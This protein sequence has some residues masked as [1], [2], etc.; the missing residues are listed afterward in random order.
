MDYATI[1][2]RAEQAL[3]DYLDMAAE[4]RAAA[5]LSGECIA[6]GAALGVLSLWEGLVAELDASLEPAYLADREW[7]AALIGPDASS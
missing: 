6:R 5:N 3:R 2:A 4:H 1:T 7:L